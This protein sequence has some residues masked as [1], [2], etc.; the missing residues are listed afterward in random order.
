[1]IEQQT[2]R[3]GDSERREEGPSLLLG[4][5]VY[6]SQGSRVRFAPGMQGRF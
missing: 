5:G 3:L 1:M 2:K 6:V 4:V